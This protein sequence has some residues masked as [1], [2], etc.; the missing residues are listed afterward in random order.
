MLVL[1]GGDSLGGVAGTAS[2]VTVTVTGVSI[3]VST[4]AETFGKLY[5]GQ[6]PASAAALFTVGSGLAYIVKTLVVNNPTGSTVTGI[7][8]YVSGTANSN[9]ILGPISLAAGYTATLSDNGWAVTN[10]NGS[11]Q[12][13]L[14]GAGTGTVTSV[15]A[16]VP[17]FLTISGSP[18]TA[19]GTLAIG[20]SLLGA[21][22]I[23]ISGTSAV[24]TGAVS[25]FPQVPYAGTIVG[26]AITGDVSG[27]ISIDVWK[28]VSSAPP[29][30]PAIPTSG[31]KI[32]ASAPI[33]ISS[34]Q[35][36]SGGS[37]AI[38]TWTTA[39][40]QWDVFG[41]TVSSATSITSIT[42]EIY[43]QRS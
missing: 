31:N 30:A 19:S 15:A 1:E 20:S 22:G 33:T 23:G 41:F 40:S 36:A 34:A 27:S 35:S 21:V 4:G 32:S 26:W 16:T 38:S 10:A 12:T 24:S 37:S 5:Q 8:F 3:T 13:S 6:L 43:I 28:T 11:L 29:S 42:L 25:R 17:S 2:A 7:Q 14:I 18:I 9:S 39:V